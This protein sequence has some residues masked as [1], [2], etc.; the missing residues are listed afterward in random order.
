M[1]DFILDLKNIQIIIKWKTQDYYTITRKE[2]DLKFVLIFM[3]VFLFCYKEN[4]YTVLK[5]LLVFLLCLPRQTIFF[6][7]NV[8]LKIK[9][10]V[11]FMFSYPKT[12]KLNWFCISRN[13]PLTINKTNSP[14]FAKH[15]PLQKYTSIYL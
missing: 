1:F 14:N 6:L 12:N 7:H 8:D 13:Y 11:F 3:K 2:F 15:L 4:K 10:K 5:Q 9:K